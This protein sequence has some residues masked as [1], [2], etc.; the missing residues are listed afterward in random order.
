MPE[1]S[2][3]PYV[4][5]SG[6][7]ASQG[8]QPEFIQPPGIEQFAQSFTGT[9]FK[10][11]AVIPYEHDIQT[12]SAGTDRGL[13]FTA[14]RLESQLGNTNLSASERASIQG[15]LDTINRARSGISQRTDQ[16]F[17]KTFAEI[18]TLSVT[19][20]R[21]VNPVRRL[22]E[23]TPAYYTRGPRTIAGSAVFIFLQE[24]VLLDIFRKTRVDNYA[25]EP[26]F[27]M[28]RLPPF[29]IIITGANEFGHEIE[30]ALFGVTLLA[31][32]MTL[33]IDDLY[34]EQQFTYVARW[35]L[36]MA[37]QSRTRDILNQV[38]RAVSPFG[39][40]AISDL[41]TPIDPNNVGV[42]RKR[43]QF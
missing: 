12:E 29:N 27:V 25:G 34:T 39:F 7:P 36:P 38:G 30:G 33:S 23:A 42:G 18:Q 19:T 28:D 22:G 5:F 31:S 10:I 13:A 26:Q 16:T 2:R 14:A 41:H 24:D 21:S 32:G 8:A 11:T 6:L 35:M 17:Y 40:G 20:R 9:D 15:Q 1:F 3:R 37:R 4:D 43:R